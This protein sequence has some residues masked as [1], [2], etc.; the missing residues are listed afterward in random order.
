MIYKVILSLFMLS[1]SSGKGDNRAQNSNHIKH[2]DPD[3]ISAL[4]RLGQ[5]FILNRRYDKAYHC[6]SAA[7]QLL[8][9]VGGFESQNLRMNFSLSLTQCDLKRGDF[10]QVI[11]RCTDIIDESSIPVTPNENQLSE[12]SEIQLEM[13]GKA[14]YRRGLSFY[15]LGLPNLAILDMKVASTLIDSPKVIAYIE[16]IMKEDNSTI[17]I[18]ESPDPSSASSQEDMQSILDY[19]QKA[20]ATKHYSTKEIERLLQ[21]EQEENPFASLMSTAKSNQMNPFGSLLG[22]LGSPAAGGKGMLDSLLDPS[23]PQVEMF[24]PLLQQFLGVDKKTIDSVLSISKAMYAVFKVFSRYYGTLVKY[25]GF[26]M[27]AFWII[28]SVVMK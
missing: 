7:L 14:R 16:S 6:Y 12:V 23:S 26:F 20:A 8:E 25:S 15:K 9:G 22:G 28:I 1:S 27:G 3:R 19:A 2:P 13:L 21:P 18:F 4:E 24:A 5:N 11:L 10:Y 17:A